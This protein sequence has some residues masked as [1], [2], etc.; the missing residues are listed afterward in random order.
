MNIPRGELF[1][2]VLTA[3]TGHVV[4]LALKEFIKNRLCLTD[5]QIALFWITNKRIPQKEWIRNRHIEIE[6]LT[7]NASK[8]WRHVDSKHMTADIGTRRGAK[9]SDVSETSPYVIGPEWGQNDSSTFPVRLAE[10]IKLS[11]TDLR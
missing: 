5:S 3:T 11:Q 4:G 10:E 9:L 2:A 8:L 7:P 6:R 1:A